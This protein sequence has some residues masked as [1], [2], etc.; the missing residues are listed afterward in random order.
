M[1]R[2]AGVLSGT[3][4]DAVD[5][6]LCDFDDDSSSSSSGEAL[7]ARVVSFHSFPIPQ[8]TR[9][10]LLRAGQGNDTLSQVHT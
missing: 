4:A 5:V 9:Q 6:L 1:T 7:L 2:V 8:D 10:R 3:S